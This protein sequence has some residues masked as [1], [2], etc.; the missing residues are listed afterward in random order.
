[1]NFQTRPGLSPHSYLSDKFRKSKPFAVVRS[2]EFRLK[3]LEHGNAGCG[4]VRIVREVLPSV[5][6]VAWDGIPA[7]PA[8]QEFSIAGIQVLKEISKAEAEF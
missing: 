2:E 8:E 3:N 6:G 5:P 4:N 1:M 7:I